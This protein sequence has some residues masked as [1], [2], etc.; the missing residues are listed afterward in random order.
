MYL[1]S[2]YIALASL[3]SVFVPGDPI[4]I[5]SLIRLFRVHYSFIQTFLA[6]G[7]VS[8]SICRWWFLFLALSCTSLHTSLVAI[9]LL[10]GKTVI[11]AFGH[12]AEFSPQVWAV[13][14]NNMKLVIGVGAVAALQFAVSFELIG[15][16]IVHDHNFNGRCDLR[17][18]PIEAAPLAFVAL[19]LLCRCLFSQKFLAPCF[20]CLIS[21]CGSQFSGSETMLCR[22]TSD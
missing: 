7:P 22:T 16:N 13:Y 3:G 18:T 10:R 20:C 12:P 8:P 9:L 4:L 19:P 1:W 2:R 17:R 15:R 14:R 11:I 21:R 6:R 5:S